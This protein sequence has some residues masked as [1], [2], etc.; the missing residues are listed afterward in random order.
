MLVI[1]AITSTSCKK[2]KDDPSCEKSVAG[3]ANSFKLTKYTVESSAGGGEQSQTI[4]DCQ[5][6]GVYVLK[7]DKTATYTETGSGCNTS[8]ET[9]NWDVVGGKLSIDIGPVIAFSG[10]L[11]IYSWDCSTLV[12]GYAISSGPLSATTRYYLSK[13]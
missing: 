9:G 5:K 12:V 13:Q 8:V 6:N 10:D 7:S 11:D 3:I 2:D 4:D 1:A